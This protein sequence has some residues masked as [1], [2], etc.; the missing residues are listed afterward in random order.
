MRTPAPQRCE[1]YDRSVRQL[2]SL[3][4]QFLA[5]EDDRTPGHVGSIAILDPSTAPGGRLTVESLRGLLRDRMHQLAPFTWKL[6]QVPLNLDHPYWGIDPKPD[7]DYHVREL[8]LPAPGNLNQLADQVARI[9]ERR[10]D[11]GRP[12][13]EIYL[14]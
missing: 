7:L 10:L 12:L 4:V 1:A 8:G 14:I 2:T 3:D 11:R 13:W 6:V 5:V 9:F